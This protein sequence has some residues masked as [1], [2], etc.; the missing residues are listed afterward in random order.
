MVRLTNEDTPSP[1]SPVMQPYRLAAFGMRCAKDG[2]AEHIVPR[3]PKGFKELSA[4]IPAW[5][6]PRG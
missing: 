2:K 6:V 4:P 3:L 1:H 5:D